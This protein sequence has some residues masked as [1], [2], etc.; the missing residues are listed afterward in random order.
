MSQTSRFRT[1]EDI[2]ARLERITQSGSDWLA[3]Q[4]SDLIAWLPYALAKP[5]LKPDFQEDE[6]KELTD[7]LEKKCPTP[8]AHVKDYLTFAWGK[9]NN[10]RGISAGR[11][12]D[13]L[14][15]WL[16]LDGFDLVDTEW[17]KDYDY[18]GK[19]QLV[20][21]SILAGVDWKKL[22][23]KEWVN[24]EDGPILSAEMLQKRVK[25]AEQ[26]AEQARH[27]RE[28]RYGS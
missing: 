6:F 28:A 25:L 27:D 21:A 14:T 5:F 1:H 15:S 4:R 17:W 12:L 11:S 18:Y 16:W 23:D 7:E 26:Y 2:V 24:E 10:C 19:T 9:A 3:T 13:H 8:M 22:D 20:V